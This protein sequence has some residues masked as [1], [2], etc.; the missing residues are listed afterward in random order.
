MPRAASK[1]DVAKRLGISPQYLHR[2]LREKTCSR[3]R[4]RQL[5]RE[6]GGIPDDYLRAPG[7]RGRPATADRYPF[8]EFL[9]DARDMPSEEVKRDAVAGLLHLLAWRYAAYSH[10]RAAT[11]YHVRS[12]EHL[13]ESLSAMELR[14][15]QILLG[16]ELWKRFRIWRIERECEDRIFEIELGESEAP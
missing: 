1:S 14:P 7:Q 5:A 6:F 8:R 3:E 10:T 9:R 2:I 13:M 12:L 4:A 15:E 16:P 11:P